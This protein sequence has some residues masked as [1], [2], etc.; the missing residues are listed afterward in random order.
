M[1]LPWR[2]GFARG[3][4]RIIAVDLL[5][6]SFNHAQL[7]LREPARGANRILHFGDC[8]AFAHCGADE[9]DI[10]GD[11]QQRELVARECGHRVRALVRATAR[12]SLLRR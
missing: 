8:N 3:L 1:D 4:A 7:A 9:F 5:V 6:F 12:Q 2:F 11:F 10:L